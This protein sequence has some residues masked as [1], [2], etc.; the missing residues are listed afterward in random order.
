MK[1]TRQLE[2]SGTQFENDKHMREATIVDLSTGGDRAISTQA[3]VQE[4][5][6]CQAQIAQ[7]GR[8]FSDAPPLTTTKLKE[9]PVM[10]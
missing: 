1:L 3:S 2:A 10:S 5:L 6:H 9:E 7:V 4:D 8:E